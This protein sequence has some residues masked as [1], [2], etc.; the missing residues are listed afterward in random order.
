MPSTLVQY[1]GPLGGA[2]HEPT[3]CPASIVQLALQ[4][5]LSRPQVS[6]GW[7]QKDALSAQCLPASH[8]PEQQSALAAH[9]LPALLHLELSAVQVLSAPHEPPQHS[10]LLVQAL[11]SDTHWSAEHLPLTQL[12]EQ[13]SVPTE[14][15]LP[16]LAQ[17]V[18]VEMQPALGSHT[19]E[20]HSAPPWHELPMIKH[21]SAGPLPPSGLLESNPA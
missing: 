8:K 5:S 4:Q 20:Q 18:T 2:A 10:S 11:P 1:A 15:A 17:V 6:P 3:L 7:M 13:Q 19:P 21:E 9:S 14:Q 16:E 12:S